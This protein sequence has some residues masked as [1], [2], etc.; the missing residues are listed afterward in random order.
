MRKIF[1]I[2]LATVLLSA[3]LAAPASADTRGGAGLYYKTIINNAPSSHTAAKTGQTTAT[4]TKITYCKNAKGKVMWYI[5]VTGT[6][7]Y[8][9]GPVKCTNT[10]V[11]TKSQSPFWTISHKTVSK[12]K[13]AAT[14][15]ATG[16]RRVNG[17]VVESVTRTVTLRCDRYGHF[18]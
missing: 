1:V 10:S 13:N 17:V 11:V 7:V 5:K 16:K 15:R 12:K 3:L 18:S 4:K 6:F 2:S 14:A 8:G 9:N